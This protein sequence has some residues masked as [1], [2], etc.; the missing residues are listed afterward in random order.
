MIELLERLSAR[1]GAAVRISEA[2]L[3]AWPEDAIATM[4]AEDLLVQGRPSNTTTCPGCERSC[5]MPV[6]VMNDRSGVP[7]AFVVCDKREDI[8]RVDVPL[9]ELQAWQTSSGALAQKIQ[10]LLGLPDSP[11][12]QGDAGEWRLGVYRNRQR[13]SHL[14]L[15]NDG[16]LTLTLAGHTVALDE[17]L[18]L[19]GTQ[20]QINRTTLDRFVARPAAGGGNTESAQDRRARLKSRVTALK[21]QGVRAYNKTV[22]DEEGISVS[23]LKQ[24]LS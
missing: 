6:H 3:A 8:N 21:V 11:V 14:A 19:E 15:V 1:G 2:E 17:V 18:T 13:A 22:A 7:A 10:Y 20:L 24:I 16:H 9:D 12:T 4:K 5:T 23:R